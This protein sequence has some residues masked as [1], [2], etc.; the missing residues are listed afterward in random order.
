MFH[1]PV[2]YNEIIHAIRPRMG[3]KYIDG[4]IGAGGHAWGILQGSSPDGLLLGLD[5][6]PDALE[7]AA[8]RLSDFGQRII[9]A[10]A[11]YVTL[12]EQMIDLN[13]ASVD[14]I[15]LDLGVSSMQMDSHR[16]GFSFKYDVPLDMRFDPDAS[17]TAADIVNK[18]TEKDLGDILYRFGEERKA[19]QI[20]HEI[21]K[22]RPLKTTGELAKI[23]RRVVRRGHSR[24]DPATRTF[25][26]IRIAVNQELQQIAEVLPI[27]IEALAPGGRLAVIAFHSL[28]DRIVKQY[29]KRESKDCICP[30][31]QP[32]CTC[33]HKA[34]IKIITKRPIMPTDT[35]IK[36]N[37]RARS[38]RLRI[39]E[40]LD[41]GIRL[42]N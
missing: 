32:V 8:K 10:R 31:D 41:D 12:R 16:R 30:P 35:E 37:P 21:V 18:L 7:I 29:L 6:D 19:K 5:V 28:E 3:C 38:A 40:K 13:W 42:A 2:L 17:R 34:T 20:A 25:Q 9:L 15:L 27:A 39:A 14:G 36:I 33:Q 4:T 23:V 26:A 24:I 1:Q 11:S 22:A